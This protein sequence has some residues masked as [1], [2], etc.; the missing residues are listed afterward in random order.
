MEF[1][2]STGVQGKSTHTPKFRA[3]RVRLNNYQQS[4]IKNGIR[5]CITHFIERDQ[6]KPLIGTFEQRPKRNERV[7]HEVIW[8]NILLGRFKTPEAERNLECSRNSKE[9]TVN[10][11][12]FSEYI[13][14][15]KNMLMRYA[16]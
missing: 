14:I 9:A 7:S 3:E 4:N 12:R 10:T 6:G 16:L 1:E 13:Y 15:H 8:K 11:I 2:F 5:L